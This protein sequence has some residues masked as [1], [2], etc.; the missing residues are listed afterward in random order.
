MVRQAVGVLI[1][2]VCVISTLVLTSGA[3][4]SIQKPNVTVPFNW[5]VEEDIVYPDFEGS[6]HDPE[7]AGFLQ[8]VSQDDPTDFVSIYYESALGMNYSSAELEGES[9]RIYQE[10]RGSI[11]EEHGL[12]A[13][14]GVSA[15]YS[16]GYNPTAN[17]FAEEIVFVKNKCYVYISAVYSG[18]GEIEAT[19]LIR[20]IVVVG[21]SS[22]NGLW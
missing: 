17:Y 8:F 22:T 11:P 5:R 3:L 1:V 10:N 9:Y 4:E 12:M 2:A 18:E 14:S 15:G 7:G 6:K 16:T 21:S 19:N 20:S 13:V